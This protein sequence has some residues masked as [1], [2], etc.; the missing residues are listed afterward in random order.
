MPFDPESLSLRPVASGDEEFL[1]VV[2]AGSRGDD[3]RGLGWDE[4]RITE[5]LRM[6][7]VAQH[8]FLESEYHRADDR[9]VLLNGEGIGRVLV[10]RSD[11]EIRGIDI[12]LLPE[13]RNQGIG[14]WLI[15]QLQSEAT[16]ARKPLRIQ[17][18][19]FS[20]AVTL[21]ERLGFSRTSETGTHY[22]MEWIA[23]L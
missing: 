4:E 21:L 19:R 7:Y 14:T 12:A 20:P 17:V 11:D 23:D 8:R 13:F 16:R 2:Y 15:T 22:Q 6:Q 10:E 1:F 18:I 9:V 5:F 3:L